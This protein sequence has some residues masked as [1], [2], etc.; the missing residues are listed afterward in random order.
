M[1]HHHILHTIAVTATSPWLFP[2]TCTFVIAFCVRRRCRRGKS[3]ASRCSSG[4]I[5]RRRRAFPT[6][7]RRRQP[8]RPHGKISR[9]PLKP[10]ESKSSVCVA[11]GLSQMVNR[12]RKYCH[13]SAASHC[14]HKLWNK[15]TS[16]PDR[17]S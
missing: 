13:S 11:D 2:Q 16:F 6:G 9:P 8:N 1:S 7:I 4:R 12:K 15:P 14:T 5:Y 10:P 17:V 3:P